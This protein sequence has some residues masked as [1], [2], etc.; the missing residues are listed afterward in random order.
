M[1]DDEGQWQTTDREKFLLLFSNAVKN[2]WWKENDLKS[3][4]SEA[5]FEPKSCH[6]QDDK[7]RERLHDKKSF[8]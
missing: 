2:N 5:L 4:S 1:A 8:N 6:V 3:L 7:E